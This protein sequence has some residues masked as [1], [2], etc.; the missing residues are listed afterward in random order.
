[1]CL[2]LEQQLICEIVSVGSRNLLFS[3]DIPRFKITDHDSMVC[4]I[5]FIKLISLF[6]LDAEFSRRFHF[7]D[8]LH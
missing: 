8:L 2:E 7:L 3:V 4:L 5:I 6:C 1:M